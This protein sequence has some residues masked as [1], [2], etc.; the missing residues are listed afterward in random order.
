MR[1]D[2]LDIRGLYTITSWLTNSAGEFTV[3]LTGVNVEG[4][5]RLEVANDGKLQAQNID[6]DLTFEQIDLDFKN[7]GFFGAVFQGLINSVGT[8]MFDSIKP[9]I[10]K[11]VNTNVRYDTFFIFL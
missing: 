3:K 5:A 1:I 8:F 6:M 2:S 9:F 11:E 4:I 10:L 7:L